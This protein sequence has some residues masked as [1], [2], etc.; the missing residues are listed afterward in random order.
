M[1]RLIALV[2]KLTLEMSVKSPI[3]KNFQYKLD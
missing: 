2:T 1:N 3:P